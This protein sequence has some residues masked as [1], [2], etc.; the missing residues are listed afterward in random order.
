M[1]VFCWVAFFN[2]KRG[3]WS[4]LMPSKNSVLV[5][6]MPILGKRMPLHSH[7]F[8]NGCPRMPPDDQNGCP[9]RKKLVKHKTPDQERGHPFARY[10]SED[11]G[12]RRTTPTDYFHRPW[13]RPLQLPGQGGQ[14]LQRRSESRW[15]QAVFG[16]TTLRSSRPTC[17]ICSFT[18][19]RSLG[20]GGSCPSSGQCVRHGR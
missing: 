12:P 2:F 6:R 19:Q 13:Y 5:P 3:N 7:V 1:C 4:R 10:P 20:S 16:A 11:V 14:S 17:L 15:L 9:E 18:R 8:K